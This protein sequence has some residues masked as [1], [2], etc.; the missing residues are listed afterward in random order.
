M[1]VKCNT[2]ALESLFWTQ[3]VRVGK[4]FVR[5]FHGY[6]LLNYLET[7]Y[8]DKNCYYSLNYCLR[9]LFW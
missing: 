3:I 8:R 7:C 1:L 6:G 5:T 4:I 9:E 2:D